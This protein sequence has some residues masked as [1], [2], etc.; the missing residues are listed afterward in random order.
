[1]VGTAIASLGSVGLGQVANVVE[2]RILEGVFPFDRA[3]LK[4]LLAA[5]LAFGAQAAVAAHLSGIAARVVGVILSGLFVYGGV[6]L[7]LGLAPEDR[8]LIGRARARL[9]G[10]R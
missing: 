5:A 8:R 7:L 2:V 1:M 3:I 6:L 4:P 10:R 9:G